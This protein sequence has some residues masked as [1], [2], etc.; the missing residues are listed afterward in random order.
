M[1]RIKRLMPG[2]NAAFVDI[3]HKKDAFLHYTDLGPKLQ[4]L[5]KYTDG[6]I[7]GKIGTHR[8]ENFEFEP[9]IVKTG[10]IDKVLAKKQNI[11]VQIFFITM[12]TVV[13]IDSRIITAF[14]NKLCTHV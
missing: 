4:S 5:L 3:G 12:K 14:M 9:E 7:N 1:G 10:K 13:Q 8:L 11:L 2:L 6:S